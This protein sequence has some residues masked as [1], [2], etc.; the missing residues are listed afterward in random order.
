LDVTHPPWISHLRFST[1]VGLRPEKQDA[2][3]ALPGRMSPVARPSSWVQAIHL[4]G[5]RVKGRLRRPL[6]GFALDPRPSGGSEVPRATATG[7][8]RA[9]PPA[10][11]LD[12]RKWGGIGRGNFPPC[13]PQLQGASWR[14]WGASVHGDDGSNHLAK[15][16]ATSSA[17]ANSPASASW[18]PA[19]I[20]VSCHCR[21]RFI[22]NF[23]LGGDVLI[24]A[25]NPPQWPQ[26]SPA[27]T[28]R[29]RFP[30]RS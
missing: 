8:D 29:P 27:L 26:S 11:G 22:F 9:P 3:P 14:G 12:S 15:T 18:I 10:Q 16:A 7:D 30:P 19:S 5:R 24:S 17:L 4:P 21:V 20:S 2:L 6:R 28:R 23:P 1:W 25:R 13:G